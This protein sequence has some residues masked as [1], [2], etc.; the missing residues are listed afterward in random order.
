M[1]QLVN[2]SGKKFLFG[3]LFFLHLMLICR[4]SFAEEQSEGSFRIPGYDTVGYIEDLDATRLLSAISLVA[5]SIEDQ[6][7]DL[8]LL[9]VFIGEGV[10]DGDRIAEFGL[11]AF[12]E[13]QASALAE[14]ELDREQCNLLRLDSE[15]EHEVHLLALDTLVATKA[16]LQRCILVLLARTQ[17]VPT[18]RMESL[19][20]RQLILEFIERL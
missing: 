11:Q 8:V 1:S 15:L 5:A 6:S 19:T 7:E 17:G 20:N 18:Q 13:E 10:I 3:A 2:I 14:L 9:L 4:P 12:S 16:D